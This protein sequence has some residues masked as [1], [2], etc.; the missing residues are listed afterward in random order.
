MVLA[1]VSFLSLGML[2][3]LLVSREWQLAFPAVAIALAHAM[4]FP[5]VVAEASAAFPV[6]F[7]GL[8]TTLILAM[9]DVG[10]LIGAP[11]VGTIVRLATLI[12]APEYPTAF[13]TV[14]LF[15]AG[16]GAFYAIAGRRENV[17]TAHS[18]RTET[19]QEAGQPF[20]PPSEGDRD[21]QSGEA[22]PMPLEA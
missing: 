15:L 18:R 19:Q 1:G 3:F 10:A 8:G 21:V 6:R 17:R 11:T 22:Q 2:T 7:R 12:G 14:A 16:I 20:M 13:I 4:L 9:F 5:S